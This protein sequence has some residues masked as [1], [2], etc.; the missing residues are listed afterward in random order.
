MACVRRI[1]LT[2][3]DLNLGTELTADQMSFE[4]V[5]K[6]AASSGFANW[7]Q[8][9]QNVLEIVDVLSTFSEIAREYGIQESTIQS[10]ENTLER[11]RVDNRA[12]LQASD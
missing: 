5:Q 10:V 4:S 11:Q 1:I 3:F 12:L 6:R 9:Q 7:R 2:V 8:A